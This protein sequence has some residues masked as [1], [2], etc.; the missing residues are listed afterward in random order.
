ME[1]RSRKSIWT[2]N[3]VILAITAVLLF[4]L[5]ADAKGQNVFRSQDDPSSAIPWDYPN[6]QYDVWVAEGGVIQ[7]N[8]MGKSVRV[9]IIDAGTIND[10]E[11]MRGLVKYI[12][13]GSRQYRVPFGR[14]RV[15]ID[16]QG[17]SMEGTSVG[18]LTLRPNRNHNP[19]RY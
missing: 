16:R 10:Y 14:Y 18:V 19:N 13:S 12:Y 2:V 11:P 5:L 6:A 17:K 9:T 7:V 1:T 8:V 15:V 4:L 3:M